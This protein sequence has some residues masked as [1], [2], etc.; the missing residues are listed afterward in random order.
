MTTNS[1]AERLKKEAGLQAAKKDKEVL[2][3]HYVA[4]RPAVRLFTDTGI[5]IKFVDYN[6]LTIDP[7]CIT[8]LDAEIKRNGIPGIT[9]AGDVNISDVSPMET[10]EDK[11]RLK[12]LEDLVKE[13]TD[14]ALGKTKDMGTTRDMSQVLGALSTS[15]TA[16]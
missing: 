14:A 8:Y 6:F 1:L 16:S 10:L 4:S 11:L 2:H 12:I 15:K 13:A 7:D 5:R 3:A 9:R